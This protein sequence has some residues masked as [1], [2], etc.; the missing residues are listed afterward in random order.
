MLKAN[1]FAA[2]ALGLSVVAYGHV[3]NCN[4][5][6]Y[7]KGPYP[8]GKM[9]NQQ[10]STGVH[11]WANSTQ[12]TCTYTGT[13]LYNAS[14]PCGVHSVSNSSSGASDTG[15]TVPYWHKTGA[16]DADGAADGPNG[17]TAT[18]DA[19][20]AAAATSCPLFPCGGPTVTISGSGQG[21]GFSVT[22]NPRPLWNSSWHYSN[23]C[24]AYTL[25]PIQPVVSCPSPDPPNP[26]FGEGQGADWTWNPYTCEWENTQGASPIVID[27]TN[28][29]FKFTD[30]TKGDYVSFDIQGNGVYQKVSWPKHGSGNAWL[31]LDR[32]GDGM[33]KDGTELFG[34]FT[35]RSDGGIPNYPNPNGFVALDWYDQP[36]QGGDMNLILDKRD[37][38]WPKLRLWI[39][40]HCYKAPDVPCHSRPDELH[41]LESK[42]VTSISLV[43][44]VSEK[45]DAVGNQF[46]V[47]AVLNPEAE[48]TPVD[49]HGQ[50]CC[51]LHQRSKDGRLAYDVFLKTVN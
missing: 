3:L 13:A 42:G 40:E 43:W 51:D 11:S 41:T 31:A 39:D 47:F 26:P 9:D 15:V 16:N 46:K 27:T 12:G 5:Y 32:D 35:P 7:I 28:T 23:T 18:S 25:P 8:Y 1:L 49:E 30:P 33:I 14:V 48:T 21:G 36:A 44:D 10:H 34:N 17:G 2:A 19:E 20:G 24:T 50:S 45:T 29:G 6:N 37:A 4:A 22:Y 38:I